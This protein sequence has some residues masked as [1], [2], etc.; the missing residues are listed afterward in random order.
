MALKAQYYKHTLN[1]RFDAGTSRGVLKNKASYF[2]KIFD[3]N[4]P[5]MEK[6]SQRRTHGLKGR[7]LTT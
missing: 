3:E 7:I 5:T 1:F 2:I 4:T 6:E